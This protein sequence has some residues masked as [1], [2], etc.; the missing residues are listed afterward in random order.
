MSNDDERLIED[1]LEAALNQPE[2]RAYTNAHIARAICALWERGVV[3]APPVKPFLVS[4]T[5]EDAE[6]EF[7]LCA[8][9]VQ[10]VDGERACSLFRQKLEAAGCTRIT[11]THSE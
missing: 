7:H 6:G 2:T 8:D 4:A 9:V 3:P 11:V 10:A 1:M 5:F